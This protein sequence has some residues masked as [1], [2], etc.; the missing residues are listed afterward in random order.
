MIDGGDTLMETVIS[1][2]YASEPEPLGFGPSLGIRAF[3]LQR[4]R[5]NL[6]VYRS[7]A[8]ERE[9]EAVGDLGGISR[10][11]LNHHHEASPA[12][13]WVAS[14]FDA[15][16]H[17]HE[18]DAA[19][20]AEICNVDATFSERHKLDED[21]EIIPI[22][23]HTSGATAFLWDSGQHRV[24]FTGDTIF[25]GRDKWRAAVPNGVSDRE[26]YIGSLELIRSL[27]FDLIVPGIASAG[28]PYY[29]FTDHAGAT[30]QIDA[31]LERLRR[32]EDG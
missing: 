26:R 7:E 14:T 30:Q 17:V 15:P 18:E 22:P 23:G 25:F 21:F 8:L 9:V 19:A 1:G 5:G 10:Q 3:L 32:G 2:L 11:Y 6:L 29:S 12:C 24:L 31:I 16:L 20:T 28:H 13:D 4:E 27:D